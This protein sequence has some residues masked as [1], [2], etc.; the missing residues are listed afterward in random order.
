M[1]RDGAL[2]LVVRGIRRERV[3]VPWSLGGKRGRLRGGWGRSDLDGR[4]GY[5]NVW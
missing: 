1:L 5:G 3:I 2:G 4:T